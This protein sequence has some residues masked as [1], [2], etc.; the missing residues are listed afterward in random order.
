MN[1]VTKASI[2]AFLFL[3]T[4][5]SGGA[6]NTTYGTFCHEEHR[7]RIGPAALRKDTDDTRRDHIAATNHI[8]NVYIC[9]SWNDNCAKNLDRN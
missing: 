1:T 8:T 4:L 6:A 2:G 9:A 7:W 3:S 5:T